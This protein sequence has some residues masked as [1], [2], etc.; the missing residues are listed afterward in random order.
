M[1]LDDNLLH[2]V[3][4]VNR[5]DS[6]RQLARI[7]EPVD[8]R[9]WSMSPQTVNAYFSPVQNS[10]NFPA[11]ILQ[12]PF[13]DLSADDAINY[14]AIGSVI[15]HEI[16][17]GF[18]DSGSEF[19]GDGR[20]HNW[21]TDDDRASFKNLTA[22]LIAQYDAFEVLPGVNVNGTLT[23]G[24]NIGDLAGVSIAY[25]AYQQSLAGSEAPVLDGYTGDQRFFIGFAQAFMGKS[26]DERAR[27]QVATDP[28]SPSLFRVNGTLSNVDAF[29][30]AFALEAGDALYR[31]SGDRVRI[32]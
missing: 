19:D 31:P 18:D 3:R 13:F 25:K 8:R 32:W 30:Q 1:Q 11:A 20:L 16:G 9:E 22:D 28:H 6:E 2:N 7:D 14:G 10:I 4:A 26:R 17:H 29:Y 15:G 23:Q 27:L 24:E 21:W 12:P 5:W